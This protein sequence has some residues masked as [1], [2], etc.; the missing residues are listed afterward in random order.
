MS[1]DTSQPQSERP[2]WCS[3]QVCCPHHFRGNVTRLVGFT[4]SG[5]QQSRKTCA[6]ARP[7]GSLTSTGGNKRAKPAR[8]TNA[9]EVDVDGR[10][11]SP[12][13]CASARCL[14]SSRR[15]A[16][17][18]A[19]SLRVGTT[20]GK[21]TSTS[22]DNHAKSARRHDAWKVVAGRTPWGQTLRTSNSEKAVLKRTNR[23]GTSVTDRRVI[24]LSAHRLKPGPPPQRTESPVARCVSLIPLRPF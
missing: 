9:R 4:S 3:R 22:G 17:T 13:V 1:S 16:A 10:Q 5:R 21:L 19:Q 20:R 6:P 15:R 2:C 11:Q 12:K 18:I 14:G 8:R 23:R 24:N 7:P